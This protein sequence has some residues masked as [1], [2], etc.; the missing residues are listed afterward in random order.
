MKIMNSV[1]QTLTPLRINLLLS[2]LLLI[3]IFCW[4]NI[5][6]FAADK[7][8][9]TRTLKKTSA[10]KAVNYKKKKNRKIM[11]RRKS[12]VRFE[13]PRIEEEFESDQEKRRDWFIS[14]RMY[15]FNK[16]PAGA[17]RKAWEKRADSEPGDAPNAL[18]PRWRQIGPAPTSSYFP[19]NWGSTSG[20][21]NAVAVSP[22]TPNIVL[23]GGATGGVWRSTDGGATFNP[24]SDDQ[25][26]LAVGS[27]AFA[28][29]DGSVVYAGMGD[30]AGGYLGT[31][32]LRS[33]DGGQTWRRINND[34]LPSQGIISKIEVDRNDPNRVYLAQLQSGSSGF[35]VSNDGGVNWTKTLS[36]T[37]N[38]LVVHPTEANTLYVAM[39]RS[40]GSTG[41]T[42]G[43]FKSIDKG[44]TWA[45]IYISPSSYTSNIKIAVTPA[46]PQKVYVLVGNA[47]G[48]TA[49]LE[50]S[51]D[52]GGSWVNRGSKFDTGQFSYNCYL[53]VHP[54][55]PDTIFVGT[56]DL[57][58]STDGG[59]NYTNLT[60][61]FSVSGAY[62]PRQS[63]SH[64]DQHSFYISPTNPNLMYI[65]N[66]GG[67]W[68][69]IDNAN[70]FQSLNASLS[71]TMFTSI[72][73]HPTDGSKTYGG[74]QDNG[75]QKRTGNSAWHEF[76][77]GDGGQTVVD[78]IDPSIVFTTYT[79]HTMS[80]YVNNGETFSARIGS[81]SIFANDRV[82]FY[83]P[84][85]GNG[86][87]S[88]LYFGTN[89]LYISTNRGVTWTAPA[90][91]LDLAD[92]GT[93]SAIGVSRSNTNVI[94]TGGSTGSVMRSGDRG[95]T[96][97]AVRNGLPGNFV[98]SI[99]VSS[100]DPNTVY[101]TVSGFG[102]GHVFK[103]TNGGTDWTDISGNLPDI[104][105]NTLVI[106]P[107]N[108][109]ILYVGTD[110]GVFR[111]ITGGNAWGT[112]NQGMPPTI[113]TELDVNA[114]GLMQAATYGRGAYEIELYSISAKKAVADFDGDGRT[115]VSVFRQTEGNWY[116]LS[117][118]NNQFSAF[119]FGKNGD[120]IASEDY[121]GDGKA[122]AAVFREGNWY[123][124]NSSNGSFRAEHFGSVDD[125]PVVGDYDGD[126]KADLAVFRPA[127]QSWYIRNSS[128]SEFRAVRFGLPTDLPTQSDFDGD[129]KTDIAVFR[130][131]N[132]T[133]Y[134]LRSNDNEFFA[135]QFG[136]NGD[137]PAAADY[138]GDG[139]ADYAVFRPSNGTWYL[140]QTS[141]GF[142][143][144]QF[145]VAEDIPVQGD[146]DGDGRTDFAVFRPSQGNWYIHLIAN[147][148]FSAFNFGL[149]T[150]V[151]IP[152]VYNSL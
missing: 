91:S 20:R 84:F 82:A 41:A 10:K 119:N 115:D 120:V 24:T 55:D 39:Q 151:P 21:I 50:I 34:S 58:R 54:T 83:P 57:W 60:N 99:T 19:S 88:T 6:L 105:T 117:S 43:V 9:K 140:L 28:P 123:I 27:I 66:D 11:L 122:D 16:L 71:L 63:K 12:N 100:D 125:K 111:S 113:V 75:T 76:S 107:R 59:L 81:A 77:T 78:A 73:L 40:E 129:G 114:N 85:V 14:Q 118:A 56:R 13:A 47:V 48:N 102:S 37:A 51:G 152:A 104:P 145:G 144:E 52:E 94:Y 26:D 126:G 68:K 53:Y 61:N 86:V 17:R 32:V 65:A 101:L 1:L 106:D 44:Q 25:V 22:S 67:L 69:S 8:N 112:F 89:R 116:W 4:G 142:R 79:G 90:G 3:I 23:I 139:K 93:L 72:D 36:G 131:S 132:G 141:G 150:D 121:D 42:G 138:D 128:N 31:G 5:S 97:S 95:A 15:P 80:R 70:S 92:G 134:G 62:D 148:D 130:P 2:G 35:W 149:K 124:S 143:G 147:G 127:A 18:L 45:R 87:D 64:P 49:R 30:K 38:D 7:I 136:T 98:T 96:W 103:T 109:N 33:N 137:R 133:W 135:A 108:P 46:S 74:T 146:Y 29:G 110:I